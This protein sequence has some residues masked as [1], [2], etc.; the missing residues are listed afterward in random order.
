MDALKNP[1][2]PSAGAPPPELTGR[3]QILR[4]AKLTLGRAK[5]GKGPKSLLLIGLRGVGKTVLLNKMYAE[6]ESEGYKAMLVEAHEDKPLEELILPSLRRILL[7]LDRLKKAGESVK[8]ALRVMASFVKARYRQGD[9]ELTIDLDPLAGRGDSGDLDDDLQELFVAIGEAA[10]SR[11]T[12]V[13]II[14]DE[15]QY[16]SEGEL[17]ALIMSIHRTAQRQLPLVLMGAG[18]PQLVGLTGKSKSYAERLFEFPELGPL[19]QEEAIEALQEPVRREKAEFTKDA[20]IEIARTTKG[21]PFFLQEWGYHSWNLA[22]RPPIDLNDVERATLEAVRRLDASF[23]RVRYDRL[24]PSEKKYLRAMAE[25]GAGPHRSGE[26]AEILKV[27]VQSVAPVRSSLTKKGM[28]YSPAHG[29][30]AF[31]VP[32]FDEFL[33][34]II[35]KMP[36]S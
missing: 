29:D 27:R 32:L 24:N 33:R 36:D 35:P 4:D 1:F 6:A 16:L 7:D 14:I 2:V 12:A 34:R 23:F 19:S 30:T 5:L 26:I 10:K 13:A 28:I 9:F 18:L 8:R 31:T 17:S 21:Y 11:Q 25:L 15:M 3:D 20:L 22:D